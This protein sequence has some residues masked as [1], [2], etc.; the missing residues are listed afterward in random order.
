MDIAPDDR[1]TAT[2]QQRYDR[3]ASTYDLSEA[4]L[5]LLIFGRPRRQLWAE[6]Q[7]A[8]ILEIGVGTG[9]NLRYHSANGRVVAMDLSPRMLA[10]AAARARRLGTKVD[11]V[12]AD[13]QRLPFRDGAFAAAA[14]TFVFCSVPDPVVGLREMQRAVG[15]GGRIHLLEHVRA[16]NRIGGWL[17][18]LI[19]PIAVRI[20]GAN[21]NRDTVANAAKAG[22]SL[23]TVETW[24]LGIIRLVR[25][26]A[27][28]VA[29]A[30]SVE[31][32]PR[33]AQ[34]KRPLRSV[35][36]G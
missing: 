13:A 19:N 31:T 18:D 34:D 15:Q 3:Q 10:R 12:L 28:A 2:T 30:T 7:G 1:A 16:Q 21:V 29:G 27:G 35:V 6:V 22:I 32:G 26:S 5:E 25:A 14:A 20:F 36:R 8:T 4:P 33:G 23:D 9:K 24:W 17:M 11:F